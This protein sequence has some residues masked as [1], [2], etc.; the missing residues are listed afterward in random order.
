MYRLEVLK[1][2]LGVQELSGHLK[3]AKN[4]GF[5]G[6]ERVIEMLEQENGQEIGG[7]SPLDLEGRLQ[8]LL[9]TLEWLQT[10]I[11][12]PQQFEIREDIYY[13]RHI[14]VD[15]PSM[16]GKYHEKKFDA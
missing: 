7:T 3:E 4:W 8:V 13:K 6:L 16:Y 14:A 5:N 2:R 11:L 9:E 15:I 10:V 1:Y 12:S